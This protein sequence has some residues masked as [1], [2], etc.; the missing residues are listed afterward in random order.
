LEG[1]HQAAD[2]IFE[3]DGGAS[4]HDLQ[5]SGAFRKGG[6]TSSHACVNVFNFEYQIEYHFFLRE[7]LAGASFSLAEIENGKPGISLA[8]L[9]DLVVAGSKS[10]HLMIQA[11]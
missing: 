3:T 10:S 2:G 5:M 4:N 11:P 9:S 7:C 8:M 1:I 6:T